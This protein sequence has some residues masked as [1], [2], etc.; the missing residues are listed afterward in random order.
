MKKITWVIALLA[1][2]ALLVT[3]CLEG[4]PE[5]EK[6]TG[7]DEA[8]T[9]VYFARDGGDKIQ[10]ADRPL[11]LTEEYLR[12]FF[13]PLGEDFLKLRVKF[14]LS[15]PSN[16]SQQCAFDGTGTWGNNVYINNTDTITYEVDPTTEFTQSWGASGTALDKK[17]LKGIC[18]VI[19]DGGE[20][21][22][23]VTLNEVT[24]IGVGSEEGEGEEGL[25]PDPSFTADNTKSLSDV[26]KVGT[27]AAIVSSDLVK[28]G[29][30]GGATVIQVAP[31]ATNEFRLTISFDNP[32]LD[33]SNATK[34]VVSWISGSVTS[35]NFNVMLT[36]KN[37]TLSGGIQSNRSALM[38]SASNTNG[39]FVFVTHHPNDWGG[40]EGPAI[41]ETD[42]VCSEIEIFSE[43]ASL[44]DAYLYF[45]SINI[46]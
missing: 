25:Q 23:I 46:Q 9:G 15:A 3:G 38:N 35:A 36:M 21:G 24:F 5:E 45:T 26:V 31:N 22:V 12:I 20:D 28:L 7:G 30:K 37:Y 33:I 29:T 6:P 34:V 10:D 11:T 1:V 13:D 42:G 39:E 40:W 4:D 19:A 44:S 8:A 18:F 17:T 27:G 14:T 32:T 16:V 43:D 41:S 2:L